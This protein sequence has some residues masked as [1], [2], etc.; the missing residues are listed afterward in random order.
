MT[1]LQVG[2]ANPSVGRWQLDVD[3]PTDGDKAA[4]PWPY[5]FEGTSAL[6]T[7]VN[8]ADEKRLEV[9]PSPFYPPTA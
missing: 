4:K 5:R 3:L 7:G 2:L 9:E 1:V 8:A 6:D